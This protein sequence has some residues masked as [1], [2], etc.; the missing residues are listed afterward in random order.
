MA[1]IID[2][3]CLKYSYKLVEK[4]SNCLLL[5]GSRKAVIER[6]RKLIASGMDPLKLAII[7]T[8]NEQKDEYLKSK[9]SLV[10][11]NLERW[12]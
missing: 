10:F 8:S 11:M 3:C 4:S 6:R 7:K 5:V 2:F 12:N 9:N 1:K